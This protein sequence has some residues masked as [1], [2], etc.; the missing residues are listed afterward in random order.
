MR[1]IILLLILTVSLFIINCSDDDNGTTPSEAIDPKEYKVQ[2]WGSSSS[3]VQYPLTVTYYKDNQQG[4]LVTEQISSQTNTDIIESRTLTSYDKLG[5]KLTV[6]NSG[7]A[8]VH[9][10]IITD[11]E[12]NEVIFENYNVNVDTGQTFMYDI[13]NNNY[14]VQ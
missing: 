8:P 13:S 12:S 7:Q 11:V 1:K 3:E 10:V 6:G 4:S 2:F 5:F 14:T 9:I